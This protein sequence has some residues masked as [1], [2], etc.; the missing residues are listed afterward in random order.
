M[1]L[2]RSYWNKGVIAS[3]NFLAHLPENSKKWS[4]DGYNKIENL[5]QSANES[6]KPN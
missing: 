2:A 6:P 4:I 5:I 1:G 3:I